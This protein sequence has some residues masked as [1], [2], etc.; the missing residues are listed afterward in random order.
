MKVL[1]MK[2]FLTP[3]LRKRDHFAFA[4]A[5]QHFRDA[6]WGAL[7]GVQSTH[8]APFPLLTAH[9]VVMIVF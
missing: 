9:T 1:L 2:S 7:Q 5:G 6:P 4:T 3:T 8:G